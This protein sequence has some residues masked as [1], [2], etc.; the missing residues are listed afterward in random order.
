MDQKDSPLRS[1]M[2]THREVGER[3][4]RSISWAVV[5]ASMAIVPRAS[6]RFDFGSRRASGVSNFFTAGR[7]SRFVAFTRF[8]GFVSG[9]AAAGFLAGADLGSPAFFARKRRVSTWRAR[10]S[11]GR[12]SACA[13]TRDH[14]SASSA[15]SGGCFLSSGPAKGTGLFGLGCNQQPARAV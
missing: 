1:N 15:E 8:V 9:F 13:A 10:R 14:N 2:Y 12:G 7:A 11:A 5:R 3:T 4:C 6:L